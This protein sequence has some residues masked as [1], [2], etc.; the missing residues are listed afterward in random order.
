MKYQ[1]KSVRQFIEELSSSSPVPGGGGAAALSGAIGAALCA[2][3]G[4]LTVGKKKYESVQEEVK[5]LLAQIQPLQES[6][7]SLMEEDAA[8][9]GQLSEVYKMPKETDEEKS[10]RAEAM[11]KALKVATHTPLE[12]CRK[13]FEIIKLHEQMVDR[14][15]L[16][17][18]SDI[19]VGVLAAQAALESGMLNVRI[20]TSMIKDRQFA[21]EVE[22]EVE[23][24]VTEGKKITQAVYQK[25]LEKISG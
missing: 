16:L 25:V 3:V 19:G 11:E 4:N 14:G 8:A 20:N 23:Q 2:M 15:N 24:L 5:A 9:F 6:M 12:I 1:D 10:R 7:L 21:S 18:I 22:K 13:A 17:A